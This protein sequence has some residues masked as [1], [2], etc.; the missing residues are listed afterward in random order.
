M[1]KESDIVNEIVVS[2]HKYFEKNNLPNKVVIGISGGKDSAVVA[3]LAVKAFGKD[4]VIGIMMPNGIQKDI[5]DS[6][7]VIDFLE[8][9]H[10]AT[11]NIEKAYSDLTEEIK[12][13]N[14][15]AGK[16]T[17]TTNTPARLRMTTLYGI[18]ACYGAVVLNTCNLS[19]D[20]LGYSTFYGD[21]AGDFAPI[22]KLTV[23]EVLDI[24]DYLG[25]PKD[26]VH[27]APG[28]GMC[29]STDEENLS[30]Q[31]GFKFSYEKLDALIRGDVT[32]FTSDEREKLMERYL[33][34]KYKVDIINI[35]HY[36]PHLY[37]WFISTT[38]TES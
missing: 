8:L 11:V 25:L 15:D 35:P 31:L 28:D 19:E 12:N 17:Y 9:T 27:K 37:N 2:M 3:A 24:G 36:E 21:S 10:Y 30:K 13:A 22:N 26:I 14:F 34:M 20:V 16:S 5:S 7:K 23:A 32:V 1:F 18:A 38:S 33:K 4:N 6:K 29:G